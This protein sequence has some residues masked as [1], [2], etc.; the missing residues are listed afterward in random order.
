M[1]KSLFL[2]PMLLFTVAGCDG[3]GD[4]EPA[5][6]AYNLLQNKDNFKKAVDAL[7]DAIDMFNTKKVAH[8]DG[9]LKKASFAV[10]AEV[11]KE[12]TP[13]D[14]KPDN[15]KVDLSFTN[16]SYKTSAAVTG[17]TVSNNPAESEKYLT[18]LKI[19]NKVTDFKGNISLDYKLPDTLYEK[20]KDGKYEYPVADYVEQKGKLKTGFSDVSY[21]IYSTDGDV[22]LDFSNSNIYTLADT[23]L[24]SGYIKLF[25]KQDE[26]YSSMV[27]F[28]K[29]LTGYNG[30]MKFGG[31]LDSDSTFNLSPITSFKVFDNISDEEFEASK[32]NMKEQLE[33]FG[34]RTYAYG[35]DAPYTFAVEFTLNK[36]IVYNMLQAFAGID[37]KTIDTQLATYGIK[38]NKFDNTV[39]FKLGKDK[40]FNLD[41][42]LNDDVSVNVPSKLIKGSGISKIAG[43]LKLYTNMSYKLYFDDNFD[44]LPNFDDY[45]TVYEFTESMDSGIIKG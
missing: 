3:A 12:V 33:R 13:E 1:K 30:K 40:S 5:R 37:A 18:D 6:K 15:F 2:I 41:I 17:Y 4:G 38:L 44:E 22:Y 11:N 14:K 23:F 19:Y 27:E 42:K 21:D 43:S 35:D 20:D 25:P 34:V 10:K 8:L 16:F 7:N 31:V 29:L 45:K 24:N 32:K 28:G 26:K 36:K 39:A 9:Q